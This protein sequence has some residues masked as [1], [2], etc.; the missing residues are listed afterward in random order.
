MKTNKKPSLTVKT[1]LKA[2]K[3]IFPPPENKDLEIIKREW[4]TGGW[5]TLPGGHAVR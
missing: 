3:L 2:G 1:N 5:C 4:P